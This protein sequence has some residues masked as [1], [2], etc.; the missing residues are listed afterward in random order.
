M[1]N[2]KKRCAGFTLIELMIVV[3]IVAILATVAIP[4]YTN[5]MIRAKVGEVSHAFGALFEGV[6][7]YHSSNGVFPSQTY[8]TSDL[9]ALPTGFGVTQSM[10]DWSCS[11][12]ASDDDVTY[13]FTF[14][15]RISSSV[16]NCTLAM[17]IQYDPTAGYQNTWGGSL[18]LK[19]RPRR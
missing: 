10:A 14:G 3:A 6:V 9:A 15:A 11:A 2:M 8:S 19:Y 4:A 12:R 18:P 16:Q 17:R 1:N 7:E 5:Y 13:Q